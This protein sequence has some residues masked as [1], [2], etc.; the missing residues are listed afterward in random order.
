MEFNLFRLHMHLH[1]AAY[2]Y[3]VMENALFWHDQADYE[4][5]IVVGT[6][7]LQKSLRFEYQNGKRGVMMPWHDLGCEC[8]S[9]WPPVLAFSMTIRHGSL[10]MYDEF[11]R[12]MMI[13]CSGL[14][15]TAASLR[16]ALTKPPENKL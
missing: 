10:K 13:Y 11:L 3:S 7:E 8:K 4:S 9:C 1:L 12:S 16:Q 2:A 15:W 5:L 14:Q 6:V